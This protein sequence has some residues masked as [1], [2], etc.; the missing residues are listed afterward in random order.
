MDI[1]LRGDDDNR[2]I[3]TQFE[4]RNPRFFHDW[5]QFP[6]REFYRQYVQQ[7]KSWNICTGITRSPSDP[8]GNI[9]E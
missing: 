8:T 4:Y 2:G 1:F 9:L 7:V 3:E 6:V 5:N